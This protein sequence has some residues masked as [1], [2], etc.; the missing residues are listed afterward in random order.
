[1]RPALADPSDRMVRCRTVAQGGDRPSTHLRELPP[2]VVED[3]FGLAPGAA[4]TPSE[5]L[6]ALLGC[7]LTVR[8]QAHALTSNIIVHRLVLEMEAQLP[9][10]P[11][12]GGAA[13]GPEPIGFERIG[14]RVHADT[15]TSADALRDLLSHAVLWSPVANML[16]APVHLDVTLATPGSA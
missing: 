12:W 14:V 6:L 9:M 16:H 13:R 8:L 5:L 15:P 2:F 10:N 4:A 7:C 1:M 11:A 3:E